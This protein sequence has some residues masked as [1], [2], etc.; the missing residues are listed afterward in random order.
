MKIKKNVQIIY[1]TNSTHLAMS[2]KTRELILD[3]L[4]KRFTQVGQIVINNS[5]DLNKLL[6]LKP[7]LVLIGMKD[8]ALSDDGD[9]KVFLSEYLS[10]NNISSVGSSKKSRILSSNK[11]LA[12]ELVRNAGILTADFFLAEPGQ[13]TSAQDLPLDFPLFIKP[14]SRSKGAGIDSNSVARNFTQYEAKIEQ[15][16]NRYQSKSLV[17]KYLS[18]REFS[19][20]VLEQPYTKLPLVMPIELIAKPNTRGDRVLGLQEKT[21]DEEKVVLVDNSRIAHT[22]KDTATKVF[23]TL[24]VSD[25][26][27]I[28]FRMDNNG[29]IYFLEAN[30]SPGL[31]HGYFARACRLNYSMSYEDMIYKITELGLSKIAK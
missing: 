4:T 30:L 27:R 6:F 11:N 7:D 17:E 16:Y 19:V 8:S 25:Y 22:L 12:K 5:S 18:G 29:L 2:S 20:A 14:P 10:K 15:I 28:D 23:R 13:F 1:S 26:A 21:E 3:V 9:T 31:G 24:G